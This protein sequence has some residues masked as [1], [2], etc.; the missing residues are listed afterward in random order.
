MK[1]KEL[2]KK[3]NSYDQNKEL[4]FYYMKDHTLYGCQYETIIEV[5]ALDENEILD[6]GTIESE[7]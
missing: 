5:D 4:R 7:D 3:L 2:I 1:V 6:E